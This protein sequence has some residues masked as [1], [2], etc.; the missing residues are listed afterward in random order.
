MKKLIF[1]GLVIAASAIIV[2]S[3]FLP[4]AKIQ[5]SVTGVSKELTGYADK[6]LG[7]SPF[8]GKFI[9]KLDMVTGAISSMG[10]VEI[11][12]IVRGYK[13]PALVNS[14]SSKAALSLAQVLFKSAEGIDKKSYLVYLLPIFAVVCAF[15]AIIGLKNKLYVLL[16][17]VIG[18]VISIGGLYNLLTMNIS[19]MVV[20][21]SI[22]KGLWYTMYAFLLICLVG[23]TWLASD[24]RKI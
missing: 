7:D 5:T 1:S 23:I 12:S 8:A 20:K 14:D 17:A 21:I 16:M 4:W 19:S 9:K 10:D 2:M 13:I 18:G 11:K 24:R 6:E 3:F 22:E 15:L